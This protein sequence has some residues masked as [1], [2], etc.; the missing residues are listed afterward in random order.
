MSRAAEGWTRRALL[1]DDGRRRLFLKFDVAVDVLRRLA[2]IGVAP[3]V[4]H[5]GQYRGRSFAI[6]P[7]IEGGHPQ[8]DWFDPHLSAVARLVATYH[9]DGP[10]RALLGPSSAASHEQHVS[11]LLARYDR[12]AHGGSARCGLPF[13]N[14]VEE[15]RKQADGLRPSSLVPT[16]GDPNNKNFVVTDDSSAY[17]LDWDDLEMSDPFR[18]VGQLLWWYVPHGRWVELLGQLG[19]ATDADAERSLYWW[20]AA[21]SLDVSMHLADLRIRVAALAF[22]EDFRAAIAQQPNPRRTLIG[23]SRTSDPR[24]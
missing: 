15:L 22:F 13:G 18:D 4:L 14:A 5:G 10:L 6:Q 1:A 2:A 21:E 19:L 12:R 16:H 23:P 17:L 11:D 9:A 3:P 20:V 8:K 24:L 7:F